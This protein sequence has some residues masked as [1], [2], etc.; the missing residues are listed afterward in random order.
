MK[1][2][3]DKKLEIVKAQVEKE[4]IDAGIEKNDIFLKYR[5]LYTS[6]VMIG[7][8]FTPRIIMFSKPN[9]YWDFDRFLHI[10]F[11]H[12]WALR[13]GKKYNE[14]D[15]LKY[16]INEIED[17]VQSVL[18]EIW[19]DMENHFEQ[20]PDKRFS[21]FKDQRHYFKG[22]YYEFHVNPEGLLET[23]YNSTK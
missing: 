3:I 13:L 14:K 17:L 9:V 16:S 11:R 6:L 1:K 8:K 20:Y 10:I 19:D 5:S 2:A 15:V 4:F 18:N 12:T 7:F 21:K 23:F 22:D